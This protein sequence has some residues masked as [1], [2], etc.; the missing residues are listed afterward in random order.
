MLFNIHVTDSSMS[1]GIFLRSL[2]SMN[3]QDSPAVIPKHPTSPASDDNNAYSKWTLCHT[4]DFF[5][6]AL[7]GD[8]WERLRRKTWNENISY[9]HQRWEFLWFIY[10]LT[11]P[12]SSLLPF[13]VRLAS[14]QKFLLL[15]VVR[16]PRQF[17]WINQ[18]K[19]FAGR[20]KPNQGERS[21]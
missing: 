2:H 4:A 12:S 6:S 21:R 19:C 20:I 17:E 7:N 16:S 5:N 14:I 15:A 9:K 1:G 10:V 11:F 3:L 8:F 13:F 18:N